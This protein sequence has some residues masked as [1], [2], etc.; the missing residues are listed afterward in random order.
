MFKK[1]FFQIVKIQSRF[2]VVLCLLALLLGYLSYPRAVHLLKS[3]ATDLIHLLPDHFP[4]VH[5]N[6][7]IQKKFNRRSSLYLILNSPDPKLNERALFDLKAHLETH[8]EVG[9]VSV[10]KRGYDFFDKFKLLLVDQEDLQ[11]V[12]DR[13]KEKIEKEKLGGLYIDLE[14]D[15]SS[16]KTVTFDDLIDNYKSKF[17]EGVE[18]K[19]RRNESGT[20][21]VLDIYPKSTD[22]GLKFFK[23][24]GESIAA[25]V[26]K[27]DFSKYPIKIDYGYAGAIKTRVDQYDA[28]IRDLKNAGL[29]SGISIFIVLYLYFAW[30][31]RLPHRGWVP[32]IKLFFLRAVPVVLIFIPMIISTFAGFAFNSFFFDKLNV[33]TSF[34]FAIIFGLG[35]DI[36]IHLISRYI[37]DRGHGL[38]ENQA[39]INMLVQTGKSSA[40]S[41]LTTV[42]SFYIM[43]LTDFRGF[44]EFGWIAGN[45]LII[46]LLAYLL[47][48]PSFVILADRLGCLPLIKKSFDL[49]L[50]S[51]RHWLPKV[52]PVA[53]VLLVLSFVSVYFALQT[54]FE[55][56]FQ[57]L[58]MKIPEREA[59]KEKLKE[60]LG[61]VNS[62][63][64]YLIHGPEDAKA[65]ASEIKRRKKDDPTPTIHFF[66][67]YYDML[68]EDQDEKLALLK[69]ID[70]MLIDDAMNTLNDEEKNLVRDFREAIAK[71]RRIQPEDIDASIHELFWGNTGL[72]DTSV[73]YIM[74]LPELHLG[75]GR[76]AMDFYKDVY[77]MH[78]NG[79]DFYA[80]SDAMVFS[81]VLQT[82]FR[83]AKV[84]ILLSFGVLTLLTIL[85]YRRV[86]NVVLVVGTLVCGIV[87]MLA[88][89]PVFGFKLNFYNMIVIPAMIGMG[90]DNSVHVLDRFTELAEKNMVGALRISGGA[91]L[92]AS[93]TTM[94]GYAGLCLA[95][96]PGLNSIG[97]MAIIG[98]GTCLVASL[99]LLPVLLQLTVRGK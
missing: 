30:F 2:A 33:V 97:W 87:W 44:S 64:A 16:S 74:P 15:G 54:E 41:I 65:I 20:V 40:T 37:R 85:H 12:H 50:H 60:T 69:K 66:R 22:S 46:A 45:G 18:S 80:V 89:L 17:T 81:E 19:F 13:L 47:F 48:F 35:V 52:R 24:F 95:H 86:R 55:W 23:H 31:I 6:Q 91:A 75:D 7:E 98:M 32:Q 68:P 63:A 72:T 84:A 99:V 56:N 51:K 34:L 94:L 27:Y 25:H 14:E 4:S 79:N 57:A 8:P 93:L 77:S 53:A 1:I 26:E 3:V 78:V 43:T 10:E 67:S 36:G 59:W 49:N 5:F 29:F 83:D 9:D 82:L 28:L 42:S 96:H 70:M 61:R 58:S 62:P 38:S 90:E 21:Y 92:M 71:T 11:Q 88:L 73:A 76:V 39:H